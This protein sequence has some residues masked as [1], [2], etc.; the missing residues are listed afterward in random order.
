MQQNSSLSVIDGYSQVK[1]IALQTNIEKDRRDLEEYLSMYNLQ[2]IKNND[3]K[4]IH[5]WHFGLSFI[6]FQLERSFPIDIMQLT[7]VLVP[8]FWLLFENEAQQQ[9]QRCQRRKELDSERIKPIRYGNWYNISLRYGALTA[10]DQCHY[11]TEHAWSNQ[12]T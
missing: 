12:S 3:N 2:W 1:L 8:S 10:L 11:S 7:S 6:R 4:K 9:Q 5:S